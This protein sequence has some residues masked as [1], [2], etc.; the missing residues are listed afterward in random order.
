MKPSFWAR[1]GLSA[2]I[3]GLPPPACA[4]KLPLC[5]APASRRPL[6]CASIPRAFARGRLKSRKAA[7][8]FGGCRFSKKA[9]RSRRRQAPGGG[10]KAVCRK[11][12]RARRA[13]T[14]A[15]GG[16]DARKTESQSTES[17]SLRKSTRNRLSHR[18]P[19]AVGRKRPFSSRKSPALSAPATVCGAASRRRRPV[20]R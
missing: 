4:A 15:A 2:A 1:T 8:D 6:I 18:Q 5:P 11:A 12:D 17:S 10:R 3:R 16:R 20:L 13:P 9:Q 7:P 19:S 14:A